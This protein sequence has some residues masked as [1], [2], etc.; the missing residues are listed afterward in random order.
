[1]KKIF[2]LIL[3]AGALIVPSAASAETYDS[4]VLSGGAHI[5]PVDYGLAWYGQWFSLTQVRC[6][7]PPGLVVATFCSASNGGQYNQQYATNNCKATAVGNNSS[8]ANSRFVLT[9][10]SGWSWSAPGCPSGQ[11]CFYSGGSDI[12]TSYTCTI[13]STHRQKDCSF[14]DRDA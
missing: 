7:Q 1:M 14:V 3:V 10:P 2:L 12:G 13:S 11:S 8:Q 9:L 6:G 5:C 4:N